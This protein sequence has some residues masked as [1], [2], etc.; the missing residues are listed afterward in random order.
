MLQ[1]LLI[2][3]VNDELYSAI[4]AFAGARSIEG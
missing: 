2:G 4:V 1:D 3:L